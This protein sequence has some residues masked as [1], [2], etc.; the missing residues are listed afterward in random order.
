M[1]YFTKLFLGPTET[2]DFLVSKRMKKRT[3]S[4]SGKQVS[5]RAFAGEAVHE[6]Y[7]KHFN[8]FTESDRD[9]SNTCIARRYEFCQPH[10][11]MRSGR[12]QVTANTGLRGNYTNELQIRPKKKPHI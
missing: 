7:L 12:K 8:P 9:Q 5:T 2:L 11:G 6:K 1:S 3:S 4:I 10:S